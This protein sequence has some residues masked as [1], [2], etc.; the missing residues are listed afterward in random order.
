MV[1]RMAAGMV[2]GIAG[3][4]A[5]ERVERVPAVERVER[6]AELPPGV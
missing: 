5:V 2:P 3:R 4:V 6:V 1:R